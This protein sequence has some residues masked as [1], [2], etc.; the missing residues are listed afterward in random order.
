MGWAWRRRE[1]GE[2]PRLTVELVPQTCWFSNLRSE[3]APEE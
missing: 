3:L 1:R 2:Q